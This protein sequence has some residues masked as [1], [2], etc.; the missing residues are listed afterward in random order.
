MCFESQTHLLS[1]K[2]GV[3]KS[4]FSAQLSF[5]LSGM[6]HQV[7]LMDTDICGPSMP[8]MLGLEAHEIHQSNLRW[9]LVYVGDNL[10]NK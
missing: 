1:S 3:G 9:S 4:T 5:A 7:G 10:G 2:G 8:K 6:D